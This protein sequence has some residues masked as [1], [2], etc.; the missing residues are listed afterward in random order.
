MLAWIARQTRVRPGVILM[1]AGVTTAAGLI[2]VTQVRADT[3]L[4]RFL[5]TDDPLRIDSLF[6][7]R[8]LGGIHTLEFVLSRRDDDSLASADTV[9]RLAALHEALLAHPEVGAVES[10]LSLLSAIERAERGGSGWQIPHDEED[11]LAAFDLLEAAGDE[12]LVRR[13][14]DPGFMHARVRAQIHAIG[15]AAAAPLEDAILEE[16]E[17]I[18]GPDYRLE[19][20]GAFHQMARDSNRLVAKQIES[21]SL[22]FVLVIAAI[23]VVFR[24][25]G[26][27]LVSI[28]PNVIPIVWTGG[29]MGVLGIDL[30]TGTA[31]IASVVIGLAV[32]DTIHYLTRYRRERSRGVA[33]AVRT[34]TTGTGRAMVASS[35]VLVVGFWVGGLGSFNPTI[36]FSWLTG[37]TM[38]SALVCDLFVLPATFVLRERLRR[39]ARA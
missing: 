30:S 6:I 5:Q 11:V 37:T 3:D 27:A 26:V 24:S 38:I 33:E 16:A 39:G 32:D 35:V 25:A 23:G 15:S 17:A 29:L 31:M 28:I 2:G 8:Q 1:I 10:V 14:V 34:T 12:D 18:L 7:D 19:V 21:F 4:V 13:V 20:T 36:Y 22:A 9:E